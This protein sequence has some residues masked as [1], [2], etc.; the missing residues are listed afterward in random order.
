MQWWISSPISSGRRGIR[1]R[2]TARQVRTGAGCGL[3]VTSRFGIA[4]TAACKTGLDEAGGSCGR[5]GCFRPRRLTANRACRRTVSPTSVTLRASEP[6]CDRI[7]CDA[8][9]ST[10]TRYPARNSCRAWRKSRATRCSSLF[11]EGPRHRRTGQNR[12][13]RCCE[14][15]ER[16]NAGGNR[17]RPWMRLTGAKRNERYGNSGWGEK[18][19]CR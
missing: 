11:G 18:R 8:R 14:A 12:G 5:V 10:S 13:G 9:I 4:I 16:W 3:L 2:Y 17:N 19:Q 1:D 7:A 6:S 15:T